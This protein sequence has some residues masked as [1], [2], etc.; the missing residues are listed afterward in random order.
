MSDDDVNK[1]PGWLVQQLIDHLRQQ[2]R[3]TYKIP[4]PEPQPA[5]STCVRCA[6]MAQGCFDLAA[7]FSVN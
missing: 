7:R 4:V 2:Q 1:L 6:N 5:H 3:S